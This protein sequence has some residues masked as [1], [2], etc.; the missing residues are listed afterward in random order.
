MVLIGSNE[1]TYVPKYSSLLAYD[2]DNELV[3][4][5][6]QNTLKNIKSLDRITAW[7][8]Y[9][10]GFFDSLTGRKGHISFIED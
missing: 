7:F 10:E 2:G 1:D 8:E 6:Q 9:E 3:R 5:I 4:K